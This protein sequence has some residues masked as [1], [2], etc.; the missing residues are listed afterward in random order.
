MVSQFVDSFAVM[1][2]THFYAAGLPIDEAGP[3]WPQLWTFILAGYVF[4]LVCA[5]ID[6]LPLY[7]LVRWLG[8]YLEVDHKTT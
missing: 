1:T 2:I 8:R 7:G 4:K 5:A 6:T 3:L